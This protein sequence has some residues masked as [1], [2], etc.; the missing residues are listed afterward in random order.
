[1]KNQVRATIFAT[2]AIACWAT[3]GTAFKLSL[4]YMPA[5]PLILASS[6]VSAAVLWGFVLV[7]NKIGLMKHLH[8]RQ[9]LFYLLLG[10]IN[11][12]LYYFVLFTA[13]DRL[14]AQQAMT[15]NYS[16]PI[17][18]VIFS[19]VW[20]RQRV[21]KLE[22]LAIFIAYLGVAVIASGGQWGAW[23]RID[24]AGLFCALLS[25]LVW[26]SYW[27]LT[28]KDRTDPVVGL[29]LSF[30]FS[31]PVLALLCTWHAPFVQL[32]W[33]AL[34]GALY[35]G[36]F[37]MSVAFV[38]WLSALKYS[39]TTAKISGLIFITPFLSLL[40]MWIVLDEP[41]ASATLFGLS[42]IVVG[43]VLQKISHRRAP[44]AEPATL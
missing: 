34:T 40:T 38:L 35:I 3:V 21:S 22:G 24:L 20:L 44:A 23:S 27:L 8:L 29:C 26:A 19:M 11:P 39:E 15:I 10:A 37:E 42:L 7:Q 28:V 16:W 36:V 18:L 13:Y 1:M 32:S 4:A 5:L 30:T 41:I 31:L 9:W 43:I 17:M 12:A 25:T 14:P 6:I 33:Q 2:S